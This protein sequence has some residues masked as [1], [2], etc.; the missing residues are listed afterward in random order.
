M[1]CAMANQAV[2]HE[3]RG[4]ASFGAEVFLPFDRARPVAGSVAVSATA[5]QVPAGGEQLELAAGSATLALGGHN[6]ERVVVEGAVAPGSPRA[7]ERVYLQCRDHALLA[8]LAAQGPPELRATAAR[9]LRSGRA[10]VRRWRIFG[11]AAIVA[12]VGGVTLLYFGLDTLVK[13]AVAGIPIAWENTLGE[14]LFAAMTAG[15]PQA[16]D[17]DAA[18]VKVAFERLKTRAAAPGCE[19]EY[20]ALESPAVNAFALPGCKLVVFTGLLAKAGRPEEVAGVLAHE[21]QHAVLR[22]SLQKMVRAA[23]LRAVL[24]LFVGDLEGLGGLVRSAGLQIQELSYGREQ[25]RE[26]DL[27]AIDLLARSGIDPAGLPDFFD[28][29]AAMEDGLGGGGGGKALSLLSTHPASAE[30]SAALRAVIARRGSA[31][32]EPLPA[33]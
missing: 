21:F 24:A 33:P 20:A 25:E 19:F 32:Y 14:S 11:I 26:A 17:K 16:K 12:A 10:L 30:R 5:L 7:G 31:R 6:G 23:G 1:F 27:S 8:L 29:L 2:T 9:L 18:V 15:Q 4:G 13:R 28:R 22:H 3:Q